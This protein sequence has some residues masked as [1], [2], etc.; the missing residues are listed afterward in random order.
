MLTT[1]NSFEVFNEQALARR[2]SMLKA[3]QKIQPQPL[4]RC[5]CV[6]TLSAVIYMVNSFLLVVALKGYLMI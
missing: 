1:G 3:K 2:E 6:H 4:A 5:T